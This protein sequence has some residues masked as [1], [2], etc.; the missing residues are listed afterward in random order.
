MARV[1]DVEPREIYDPNDPQSQIRE[2]IKLAATMDALEKRRKELR[3]QLMEIIDTEGYEDEKGNVQYELEAPVDGV[4]RLEKQGR[5][6]RKID[7]E[8]AE[9]IIEERGLADDV[10]QMVRVIDEDALMA[11]F[12]EDKLTEEELD[13]MFPV[14]V[15]W[16]LMTAKK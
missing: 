9:R 2:Y 10:Y 3:D 12:Y 6:S 16:A 5:R 13:E 4:L 14:K 7:E 15:T 11:A 8:V 1:T